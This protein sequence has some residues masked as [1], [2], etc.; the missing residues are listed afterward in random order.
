MHWLCNRLLGCA[1]S[2]LGFDLKKM[3]VD[4]V[5]P[6]ASGGLIVVLEPHGKTVQ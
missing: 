6:L 3:R 4:H 2:L 5:R 1:L